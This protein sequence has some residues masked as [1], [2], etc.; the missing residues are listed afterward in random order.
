MKPI[1]TAS[2]ASL[3]AA[4]AFAHMDGSFHT[5]GAE[6]FVALAALAVLGA[7]AFS[8]RR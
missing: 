2:F 4:P 1:L 7:L 5:H 3:I 6:G 8:A